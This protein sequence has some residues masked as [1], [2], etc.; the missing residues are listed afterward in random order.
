MRSPVHYPATFVLAWL[1]GSLPGVLW[2]WA[3]NR[4]RLGEGRAAPWKALSL[5]LC[6]GIG[7]MLG[8]ALAPSFA[9]G[10]HAPPSYQPLAEPQEGA[11]LRVGG[12][13]VQVLATILA[14]MAIVKV[15]RHRRLHPPLEVQRGLTI[16]W[17]AWAV[18]ILGT[19]VT[20]LVW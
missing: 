16:V 20:L 18:V 12:T 1:F 19:V 15:V 10:V 2:L 8:L 14:V 3:D 9:R 11:I 13:S 6:L 7:V 17:M 5:L 4:A